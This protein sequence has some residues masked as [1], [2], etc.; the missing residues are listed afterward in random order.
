MKLILL[1]LLSLVNGGFDLPGYAQKGRSRNLVA[2]QRPSQ[3][4]VSDQRYSDRPSTAGI[5]SIWFRFLEVSEMIES[6][7]K[8]QS[9]ENDAKT[10]KLPRS[11]QKSD[12]ILGNTCKYI[13]SESTGQS[14]SLLGKVPIFLPGKH[15]IT[16]GLDVLLFTADFNWNPW[17]LMLFHMILHQP[18]VRT[19]STANL[20]I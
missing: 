14:K 20:G 15:H 9:S 7:S 2:P 4:N 10:T 12:N 11:I 13:Y 18:P 19:D 3:R 8:Q 16:W 6:K 1:L 17:L 5:K